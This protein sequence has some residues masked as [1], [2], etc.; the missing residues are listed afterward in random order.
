MKRSIFFLLISV[1]LL[2]CS[3]VETPNEIGFIKEKWMQKEGADYPFR[4]LMLNNVVYNDTIRQLNRNEI[5]NLLGPPDR[6][7]EN[8]IYYLVAQTRLGLWPLHSRFL[9]IKFKEEDV[10]DW[11][12]IHE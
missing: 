12:K 3:S 2:S 4:S 6:D 8:H 9:V 5:L 1:Y 7:N 11:I 10:V